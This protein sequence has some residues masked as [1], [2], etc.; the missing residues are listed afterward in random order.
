MS[1]FQYTTPATVSVDQQAPVVF[2]D[3][4]DGRLVKM[5][6]TREEAEARRAVT[7]SRS[8][9]GMGDRRDSYVQLSLAPSETHVAVSAD[10]DRGRLHEPEAP[11][12]PESY[13]A[14]R[15]QKKVMARL[16]IAAVLIS[17]YPIGDTVGTFLRSGN[18]LTPGTMVENVMQLPSQSVEVYQGLLAT[19]QGAKSITDTINNIQG[20]K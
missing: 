20:K 18:T 19:I 12:L 14:G 6:M 16:A 13:R 3:I 17:S 9:D 1:E 5:I 4:Q 2:M 15:L 11:A 7:A 8:A 10:N